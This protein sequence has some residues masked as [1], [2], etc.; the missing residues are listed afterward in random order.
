MIFKCRIA[1]IQPNPAFLFQI[2]IKGKKIWQRQMSGTMTAKPHQ[3]E[4]MNPAHSGHKA[5]Q[6]SK[7]V[8]PGKVAKREAK[9]PS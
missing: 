1:V 8:D 4:A 2:L 7:S 9:K 3:I 6:D 5:V